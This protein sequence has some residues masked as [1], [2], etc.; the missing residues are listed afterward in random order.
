MSDRPRVIAGHTDL[1]WRWTWRTGRISYEVEYVLGAEKWIR[2]TRVDDG[3]WSPAQTVADWPH[4][5]T[6]DDAEST[7]R[8]YA[9][10]HP[11]IEGS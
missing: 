5:E 7:V 2:R 9:D 6:E 11:A 1:S 4:P 8:D 3:G 10:R